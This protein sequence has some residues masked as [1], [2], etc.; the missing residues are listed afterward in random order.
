M[1]AGGGFRGGAGSGGVQVLPNPEDRRG[2]VAYI[3][4]DF[5]TR[6]MGVDPAVVKFILE[7][8]LVSDEEWTRGW[9]E[10]RF[11]PERVKT[12][13]E[14]SLDLAADRAKDEGARVI[15]LPVAE[16]V[17]QEARKRRACV[18]PFRKC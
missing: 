2:F 13:I 12:K 4:E 3:V 16:A 10:R 11:Q 8:V 9:R 17:Y 1:E 15:E 14:A 18:Y 7:K 6:R 5:E